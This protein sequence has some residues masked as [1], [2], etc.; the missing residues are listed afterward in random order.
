VRLATATYY[1]GLRALG[2]TAL[3]RRL[4]GSGLILCYHNVVARRE[5]C[6]GDP[7][8]H[9]PL[10]CFERQMRW[11]TDHYEVVSLSEFTDRLTSGES[12]RSVA[13]VT[14]DDGYTGVFEYGVPILEALRMPAT[15]FL[16]AERVGRS[17]GF[18]WDQPEIIKDATPRRRDTWLKELRGDDAAIKSENR[19]AAEA[20]LPASHRPAGWALIRAR[21]S[22]GRIDLG[23]HSA[24]HRS[25]PTLT[26]E[27]L[28]YEIAV[29]RANLQRVTG[30]CPE[31]FSY[32]Y[33][34]WD[35]RVRTV[36]QCSGYRAAVTLDCGLNS[37]IADP[38]ALR[39]INIPAGISAPAFQAWTAGLQPRH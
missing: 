22:G 31:F 13:A 8:L 12:L 23:A 25:L 21:V 6:V 24:T 35:P 20:N 18:W 30:L 10:A 29:T 1:S 3:S 17:A 32:P 16:V 26:D 33:G 15:V 19:C 2:V 7:G 27:E 9:M 11:L 34:E 36:V 37:S 4:H 39:R 14:F 38:W 5:E 28:H